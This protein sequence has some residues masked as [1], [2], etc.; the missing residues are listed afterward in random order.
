VAFVHGEGFY[1]KEGG[2]RHGARFSFSQPNNLEI[3]KGIKILGK[4][5]HDLAYNST[6]KA[7]GQ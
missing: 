2:G 3:E 5:L 7:S 4:L 6:L 1:S